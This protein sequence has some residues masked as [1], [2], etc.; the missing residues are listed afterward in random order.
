[1]KDKNLIQELKKIKSTLQLKNSPS[2]KEKI[3]P[4]ISKNLPK[5]DDKTISQSFNYF[6]LKRNKL[7]KKLFKIWKESFE[8]RKKNNKILLLNKEKKNVIK[9]KK[10]NGLNSTI[11]S[12]RFIKRQELVEKKTITQNDVILNDKDNSKIENFPKKHSVLDISSDEELIRY[13]GELLNNR[14]NLSSKNNSPLK[15][16]SPEKVSRPEIIDNSTKKTKSFTK[17]QFN[18]SLSSYNDEDLNN[19]LTP[20]KQINQTE[21]DISKVNSTKIEKDNEFKTILKDNIIFDEDSDSDI[22]EMIK[23]LKESSEISPLKNTQ[24]L[25]NTKNDILVIKSSSSIEDII[26]KK[27]NNNLPLDPNA[28]SPKKSF[29]NYDLNDDFSFTYE[30]EDD[31][32]FETMKKRLAEKGITLSSSEDY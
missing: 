9:E 16:S 13:T 23:K 6:I 5:K 26:P 7:K 18:L 3:N 27:K 19:Y 10:N 32:D 17:D 20:N 24:N 29:E 15:I 2:N 11:S 14:K 21:V 22:E 28:G 25:S 31:D 8:K 4:K 1:M 30:E 12:Q